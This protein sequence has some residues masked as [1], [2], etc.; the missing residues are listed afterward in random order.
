MFAFPLEGSSLP[1]EDH[2]RWS[3]ADNINHK[4]ALLTATIC[5]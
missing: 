2:G 4:S 5:N 3:R 1:V